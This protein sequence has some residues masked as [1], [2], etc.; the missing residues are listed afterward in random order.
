MSNTVECCFW[1]LKPMDANVT[2]SETDKILFR[3]YEPCPKCNELFQQGIHVVGVSPNMVM[4]GM[5]SVA[6]DPE[7]KDLYPTGVMFLASEDWLRRFL[8]EPQDKEILELALKERRILMPDTLVEQIVKDIEAQ[9]SE[10]IPDLVEDNVNG[11]N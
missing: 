1:C 11:N 4:P 9:A 2:L 3:S 10:P 7:G 8:S 5:L 6:Q